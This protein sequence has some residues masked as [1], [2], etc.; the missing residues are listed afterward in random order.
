M[1][2]EIFLGMVGRCGGV[3]EE[4][5]GGAG[6]KATSLVMMVSFLKKTGACFPRMNHNQVL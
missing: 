3:G 6:R 1:R 4:G 2:G 5:E